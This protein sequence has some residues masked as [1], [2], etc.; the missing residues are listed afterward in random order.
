MQTFYNQH[1]DDILCL[2]KHPQQALVATGQIGKD[3]RID[4]WQMDTLATVSIIKDC[5][6]GGVGAVDFHPTQDNLLVA[7]GLDIN[8]CVYVL[9]WRGGK[10]LA[11]TRGSKDNLYSL[12]FN[13]TSSDEVW[14][15][16]G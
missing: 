16:Q 7:L 8:H 6:V 3:G 2:S 11:T 1:N 5:V 9:D 13:P 14:S 12:K 10:V 4:V 15:G